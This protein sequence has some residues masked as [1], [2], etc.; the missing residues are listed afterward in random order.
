MHPLM[1]PT[2]NLV[3][4]AKI[5]HDVLLAGGFLLMVLSPCFVAL[6]SGRIATDPNRYVE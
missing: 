4:E 3:L 5:M 2:F 1:S 6:R